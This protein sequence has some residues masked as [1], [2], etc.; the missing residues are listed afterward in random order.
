[1]KS[2]LNRFACKLNYDYAD[3][4]LL[5]SALTHR[6]VG[7]DNNERLEFLGDAILGLVIAN[8]LYRR[9]PKASEG[10]LSRLRSSLVKG[11]TLAVLATELQMGDYLRLGSGEMKSGG[12]R[13]NSILAGALEAVICSVFLDGGYPCCYEL[14]CN[15]YKVPLE[16]ISLRH[17]LK[18][19][20]TRLQEY[21]QSKKRPLPTYCVVSVE[22][23]AH[24]QQFEVQCLVD[25]MADSAYGKGNSR[26]KAEQQAADGALCILEKERCD[27]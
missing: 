23:Q 5:E 6:S 20:K 1:M 21:L 9:F 26:R 18:D 2:D 13:R 8:E 14:I 15:L 22:G 7:S 10:D 19:P 12:F 16:S 4:T 25:G 24:D 27:K 17:N 3:I 11:D